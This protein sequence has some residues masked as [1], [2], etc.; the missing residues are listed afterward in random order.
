MAELK[1][2]SSVDTLAAVGT[3]YDSSNASVSKV[4]A[5]EPGPLVV[6][7]NVGANPTSVEVEFQ[8][9]SGGSL[10]SPPS[11]AT[12]TLWYPLRGL[13]GAVVS[14][15][16]SMLA[17]TRGIVDP[18]IRGLAADDTLKWGGRI[19]PYTRWLRTRVKRTGG[20]A[21]AALTISVVCNVPSYSS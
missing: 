10:Q 9:T 4:F 14:T 11:A 16:I 19:P 1:V 2:F 18:S 15:E 7:F 17:S 12:D 5:V 8:F 13:A 21:P 6:Y 20:T 3:S